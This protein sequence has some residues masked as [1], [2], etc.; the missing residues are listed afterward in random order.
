MLLCILY[1]HEALKWFG[2]GYNDSQ[3]YGQDGVICFRGER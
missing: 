3:F 1:S 2:W